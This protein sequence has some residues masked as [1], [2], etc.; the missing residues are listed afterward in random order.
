[1]KRERKEKPREFKKGM[2]I[3]TRGRKRRCT[4]RM[5]KP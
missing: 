4:G 5:V 2:I 3:M 1:M